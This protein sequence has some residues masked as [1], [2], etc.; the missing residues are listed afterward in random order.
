MNICP[1]GAELLLLEGQ[2]DIPI[3]KTELIV[4]FRLIVKAPILI[5]VSCKNHKKYEYIL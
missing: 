4:A 2:S 1:V 5:T 3:R